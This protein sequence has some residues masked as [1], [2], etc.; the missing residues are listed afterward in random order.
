MSKTYPQG[1]EWR[2][3]DLHIHT[4]KSIIQHYGGDTE[5]AWSTFIQK[6]ASLPVDIKAIAITDYLF[7]DGYEYLLTRRDEFPNI[8]LMLP[9][10][11]FRLNTFSGTANNTKRH[12]FHVLFD[13]SV[14]IQDIRDQLLYCLSTGYKIQDGTEW[15]Q[16]PTA[17]S[18]EELGRQIKTAAPAS[19]TVHSKSDLEVGFDNITYKREDI[20]KLLEKN[21]FKGRFVT[22]VGYSE[23]DQSKWD[24][25][26]AEKRSLINSAH[27][28]LTNLDDP[29][30]IEENC[31]DLIENKLNSLV[32]HASDAH[33]LDRVGQTMLWIKA[34]PTFAGLK[35]VLNE[36]EARVFIGATPP[37]YKPDHKIISQV[38]IPS[39]NGWFAENFELKLNRDLVTVI[40]GRG[41]GK[42]A[43]AEV[44]AYGAGSEDETD[45]A[46][47]KKAAKHKNSIKGT[48][49][50]LSW[51]DGTT[52]EFR[53]GD[54]TGDHGL[55]RYLPQG[56]V[57]E[58]C[59]HKN[60]DKLQKQIEKVIFQFL[61]ET[62][63]MGASDFDELRTRILSNFEYE[64]GQV[65]RKI[66]DINQ[67]LSNL[68]GILAGL[69]EKQKIFDEKK[70]ELERLNKSLPELP[71][72][73]KKGQ[74]ELA[75]LAELKK[76][77]ESKIIELQSRLNTIADIE[78]KIKVFKTQIREY[79]EDTSPLLAELGIIEPK[80]FEVN[81]N[82]V[83]I[84][85][86][87]DAQK[88]DVVNKL[89]ILRDGKKTE[90]VTL[91]N[92]SVKEL[93]FANLKALNQGIEDK[94]KETRAFETTK[95]K[96]QQQKKTAL[97]LD[98]SIKALEKEITK[99]QTGSSSEKNQLEKERMEAYC[100]YFALLR[101]E[102][103]H[104]EVLYKPLQNSLLAGTDTDKKLVFEAQINYRLD[105]HAKDGLDIIDRT[106]KGSFREISNLKTALNGFWDECVRNDFDNAALE[107]ELNK[108]LTNFMT[109]EGEDVQIQDQLRENYTLED[110]YNWLFNPTKFEIVSSLQFDNTDL[111]V[112]SPG[113]KGIILLMLFLEI[114]KEDYRP[115]I[116]DQPE[117]NL[118]NLS[119][120]KDLIKYF[121][122][123]KEYRQIIMVTHNPNLVVN[124]DAEQVIV[125]NYNGK[126]TPRL[127]YSSG[128]LEDQ[129]KHIPN[130]PVADL[131]DGIIEK[132][133]DILEGGEHAFEK[134]KKKY[135]IS[136]KSQI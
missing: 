114:D 90:V 101:E 22:A 43:L 34:D 128:S 110:F 127:E 27:F 82:E 71:A 42:S 63:R 39:S 60:S 122:D 72:E 79:H 13:P 50:S 4:P 36:P 96:Y 81:I 16:T 125:A 94:Q 26:A 24:Q 73:D 69:P 80:I 23:W 25:S 92:I 117:E 91:I 123:R 88:I 1:S 58:L 51:A 133:C 53:V 52:T 31:K 3:W 66:R 6:L 9:N 129:A 78:T 87:L 54:L 120:Y 75:S 55:V 68:S 115:L 8:E 102:K 113:Q 14:S 19:N 40:G 28:A 47:L 136:T 35:Q 30:K 126:R 134:R 44:I 5:A 108:I 37:N 64:K 116:I 84:K 83:D 46:F 98:G 131:E 2:K 65:V 18:L 59:S 32:L 130:I 67:K 7:C 45:D 89:K 29:A 104:M 111:Y 100:S 103:I 10:I 105:Q 85:A 62:E 93:P 121:R 48:L 74:E 17:R 118:D 11:E 124:T 56:V 107:T 112:L 38:S 135:Q 86:L 77:F 76:K 95:I 20:E 119:V 15:Q 132:V 49:I 33:G 12:N 61:D 106:R 70:K 97:A 57:E 99:I 109:C 21:C 41:S